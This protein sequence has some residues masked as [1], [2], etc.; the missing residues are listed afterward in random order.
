MKLQHYKHS[1]ILTNSTIGDLVRQLIYEYHFSKKLEIN[2]ENTAVSIVLH[3]PA[4]QKQ[5]PLS[6]FN[7]KMK[8]YFLGF[9][10]YDNDENSQFA[11]KLPRWT[12][13]PYCISFKDDAAGGLLHYVCGDGETPFYPSVAGIKEIRRRLIDEIQKYEEIITEEIPLSN[14]VRSRYNSAQKVKSS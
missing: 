11:E 14:T 5:I 2:N 13:E 3:Y 7:E 12:L 6:W 1:N 10:S 8:Y 4:T 9:M